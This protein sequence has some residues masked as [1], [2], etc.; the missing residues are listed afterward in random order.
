MINGLSYRVWPICM[1]VRSIE[2]R[3]CIF[4]FVINPKVDTASQFPFV[5]S[6]Y[7]HKLKGSNLREEEPSCGLFSK[8]IT[9]NESD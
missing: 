8:E 5:G 9:N 3:K 6:C 7:V 4:L 1:S 2:I